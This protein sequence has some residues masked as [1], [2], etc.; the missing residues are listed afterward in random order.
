VWDFIE[1]HHEKYGHEFDSCGGR[2]LLQL[3]EK[4]GDRKFLERVES[5]FAQRNL[6]CLDGVYLNCDL[7]VPAGAD[8]H[9]P[10]ALIRDNAWTWPETAAN[11]GDT[12]AYLSNVTGEEQ[13]REVAV[14]HVLNA[15]RWLFDDEIRLWQHVGRPPGPDRR[16]A[17]WG[18]GNAWF[19]YAIRGLLDDLPD[20]HAAR[21]QL[22]AL[23][24]AG[25]EGLLNTQ[26]EHG[27]WHN[28]L[29]AHPGESRPCASATSRIL[30]VFAHAYAQGWLRD[31]RIPAMIERAWKGLKTKLWQTEMFAVCVGTSYALCRQ[32]YLSRPHDSMR[33]SRSEMLLNWI[34]LQRM[35]EVAANESEI[36]C[37]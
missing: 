2:F 5:F 15:H 1:G 17:P 20:D 30:H 23:L 6:W 31:E 29:D 9:N 11:I 12:L 33:T 22:V 35:R 37:H 36:N 16:S 7:K 34:E 18:R 32:V 25:L 19:L 10:P 13:W 21:P 14:R 8:A 4:T 28:V 24:A 3:F 27:L 26:D